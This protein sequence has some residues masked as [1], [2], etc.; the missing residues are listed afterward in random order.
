MQPTEQNEGK[1]AEGSRNAP[2]NDQHDQP[3]SSESIKTS[4]MARNACFDFDFT[5]FSSSEAANMKRITS[6]Q[7]RFSNAMQI[8]VHSW[9]VRGDETLRVKRTSS[10]LAATLNTENALKAMS[11][12]WVHKLLALYSEEGRF[13]HTVCHIEEMF[14]Y[15]D[16]LFI[17]LTCNNN[18]YNGNHHH[19]QVIYCDEEHYYYE[20]IIA[21]SIFFHDAIYD[22]KSSTNEE[23]SLALYQAFE[24]ELFQNI[25][26]DR[27]TTAGTCTPNIIISPHQWQYSEAVSTFILATKSHNIDKCSNILQDKDDMYMNCLKLFIDAD[28]A[29]LGK[30]SKAYDHYASLIRQEYI[31]VPKE[32]YCEKRAQVLQSFVM[33]VCHE[34]SGNSNTTSC[35][36]TCTTLNV[37]S[38][39]IFVSPI[40]REALESQAIANLKR[41]VE[42]LKKGC[43][44]K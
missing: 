33:D 10:D 41:E 31:H 44:P 20:A 11:E 40:M 15:V 18:N 29:V 14:G 27:T 34:E 30:Q 24:R 37:K 9:D 32:L 7:D 23:D 4:W 2:L 13:Y 28:M 38:K 22:A 21:F 39:S 17:S 6:L 35:T 36:S 1:V 25:F 42:L 8:M 3:H 5:S 26:Q 16:L 43:I 19:S 12:K